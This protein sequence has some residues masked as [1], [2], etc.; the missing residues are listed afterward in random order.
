MINPVISKEM[1]NGG[2]KAA[3]PPRHKGE[4]DNASS[5]LSCVSLRN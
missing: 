5:C 3:I 1:K 2:R 4:K